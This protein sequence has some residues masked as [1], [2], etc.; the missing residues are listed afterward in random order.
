MTVDPKCDLCRIGDTKHSHVPF[1]APPI[2][3]KPK[4]KKKYI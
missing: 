2:K 3:Y 4:K 1:Y